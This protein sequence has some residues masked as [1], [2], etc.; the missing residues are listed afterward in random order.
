MLF[1]VFSLATV[2]PFT[3][4]FRG[5]NVFAD[6]SEHL[7]FTNF[8]MK[9]N[10]YSIQYNRFAPNKAI[11]GSQHVIQHTDAE[12]KGVYTSTLTY[13]ATLKVNADNLTVSNL[14]FGDY[15]GKYVLVDPG[16]CKTSI[17]QVGNPSGLFTFSSGAKKDL[18]CQRL[19]GYAP[20]PLVFNIVPGAFY[21]VNG[22]AV[23]MYQIESTASFLELIKP[24]TKSFQGKPGRV[25]NGVLIDALTGQLV[26]MASVSYFYRGGVITGGVSVMKIDAFYVDFKEFDGNAKLTETKLNLL[27]VPKKVQSIYRS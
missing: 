21:F 8:E 20:L 25:E 18:V 22:R 14:L 7:E 11:V 13:N 24:A 6:I 19:G 9:A 23:Q 4:A 26:S 1:L 10:F 3:T 15:V 12:I 27:R 5:Q 16:V 2:L 17:Q